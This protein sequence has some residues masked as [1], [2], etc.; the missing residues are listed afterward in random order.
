MLTVVALPG[1]P[2]SKAASSSL[3]TYVLSLP[4]DFAKLSS[5]VRAH[6]HY[7]EHSDDD[8]NEKVLQLE[9]NVENAEEE[10]A[11]QNSFAEK[12]QVSAC[13]PF[14]FRLIIGQLRGYHFEGK[15]KMDVQL[16]VLDDSASVFV[17]KIDIYSRG[18]Y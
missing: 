3:M 1:G 2:G 8:E 6:P 4:G 9:I 15:S 13:P 5:E 18:G 14:Y 17:Q 10:A 16:S 11:G 7:E 12:N